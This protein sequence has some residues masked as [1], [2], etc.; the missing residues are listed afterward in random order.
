MVVRG[1]SPRKVGRKT[2]PRSGIAK[3]KRGGE[4]VSPSRRGL[5]SSSMPAAVAVEPDDEGNMVLA[6]PLSPLWSPAGVPELRVP[7][8][9]LTAEILFADGRVLLGRIF[10]PATA[11][12]HSGAMR[13]EEWMNEPPDFFPFLPDAAG[14]P[15]IVNK[16]EILILSVPA[17]VD[18]D[19]TLEGTESL[20]RRVTIECGGHRLTGTLVIDMPQYQSR[21][22][23]YLNR[24]GW[25]LTL[26]DGERH[27]LIQK[28]RI[29]RVEE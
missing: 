2:P 21:V 20:E 8:V 6:P 9:A 23:D 5:G 19:R 7:T 15:I 28:R 24:A 12:S 13:P 29:T 1:L 22:L 3:G 26:R 25:F 27:H 18:A 4:A 11:S 17:S 10:V 16:N 14:S